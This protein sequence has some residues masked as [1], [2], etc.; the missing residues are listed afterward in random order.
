MHDL[1]PILAGNDSKQGDDT[2]NRCL[3]IR[4]SIQM[5]NGVD[6]IN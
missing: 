5:E 6:K 2:M 4:V 1:I 3:E